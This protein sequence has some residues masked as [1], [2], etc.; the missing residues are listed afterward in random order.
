M[1]QGAELNIN[2]ERCSQAILGY[3]MQYA[4]CVIHRHRIRHQAVV[5]HGFN[6]NRRQQ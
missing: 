1:S 3:G 6:P 5:E 2:P 4:E